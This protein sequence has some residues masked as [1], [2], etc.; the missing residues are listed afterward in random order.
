MNSLTWLLTFFWLFCLQCSSKEGDSD[1]KV[2]RIGLENGG[3]EARYVVRH[4]YL[5]QIK[6][7]KMRRTCSF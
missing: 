5:S 2:V 1:E 6:N 4:Y 7:A 3:G